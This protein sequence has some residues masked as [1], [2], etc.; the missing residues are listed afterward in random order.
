MSFNVV[1]DSED[2][3]A[4]TSIYDKDYAFDWSVFEKDCKYEMS[5][6]F[7]SSAIPDEV[8][9]VECIA[10]VGL[11]TQART[12][13]AG[14]KTSTQTNNIIGLL[15]RDVFTDTQARQVFVQSNTNPNINI[16]NTPTSNIFKVRIQSGN[17]DVAT[18]GLT[19]ANYI[20]ILHFNKVKDGDRTY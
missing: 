6:S 3:Y 2:S 10:L 11:G 7:K 15:N 14:S 5:F 17:G 20:L 12:F 8:S 9:D 1:I 16:N 19:N 13:T 18:A 4:T